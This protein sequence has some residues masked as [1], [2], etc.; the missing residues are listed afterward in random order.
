MVDEKNVFT[1]WP[2]DESEIILKEEKEILSGICWD[3]SKAE[4]AHTVTYFGKTSEGRRYTAIRRVC[5]RCS[6]KR[7][8][9]LLDAQEE[10]AR[11]EMT[12]WVEARGDIWIED[13]VRPSNEEAAQ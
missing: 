7:Q 9:Y 6:T 10:L 11:R 8:G 4:L 13:I 5:R 1:L 2:R 3:C 12:E